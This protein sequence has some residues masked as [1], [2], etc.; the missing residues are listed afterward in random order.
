MAYVTRQAIIDALNENGVDFD[1]N[2]TVAELRPIFYQLMERLQQNGNNRGQNI[3][4]DENQPMPE[5]QQQ[6]PQQPMNP[7]QQQQQPQ[8]QNQP[9]PNAQVDEIQRLER[10]L[11][12][13]RIKRELR[14]LQAE[15]LAENQGKRFDFQAFEAMVHTFSGD[16]SYDVK[17][18]F[19]DIED[20]SAVFGCSDRDKFVS[21]RRLLTG[22]AKLF[23]RT[24][25]AN[26]Y[27]DLKVA[28]MEEF[29]RTFTLNEVFQ[30][31]KAR[32]LRSNESVRR[33][34]IEMQEIALRAEI[35]EA[36]LIECIIDGIN[37]ESNNAMILMTAS[38]VRDLKALA[39]RYEKKRIE[40][41]VS[42]KTAVNDETS[43]DTAAEPKMPA[44][45][46]TAVLLM[47]QTSCSNRTEAHTEEND[48]RAITELELNELENNDEML[49]PFIGMIV[50]VNEIED[51]ERGLQIY[52]QLLEEEKSTSYSIIWDDNLGAEDNI[53]VDR[54][55][56]V[57]N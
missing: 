31:L 7:P 35:P 40:S 19:S 32:N 3:P 43:A 18:W 5:V 34:I 9:M 13:A 55:E 57:N 41:E 2:N 11:Q 24:I 25:N 49:H 47:E 46:S 27:I 6:Q 1:E 29:G 39:D 33:Y 12:I 10:E 15:D 26:N 14:E 51:S 44:A 48:I 56:I 20:A 37:D 42:M 21:L 54:G 36:D 52:E 28:L 17:K 23:L 4:N 16:D 38:T 45:Q 53:E 30:Q 8:Q 50:G 22:T